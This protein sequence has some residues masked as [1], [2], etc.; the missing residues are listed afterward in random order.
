MAAMS[1]RFDK[2][3]GGANPMTSSTSPA[4]QTQ[5]LIYTL[6]ERSAAPVAFVGGKGANLRATS[7]GQLS[8]A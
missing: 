1:T 4:S 5:P 2:C 8:R 6:H 3:S 7:A